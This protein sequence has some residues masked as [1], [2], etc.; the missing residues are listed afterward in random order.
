MYL[1]VSFRHS[2]LYV[3]LLTL[4]YPKQTFIVTKTTWSGHPRC[5]RWKPYK[6]PR[7]C[8]SQDFLSLRP[9]SSPRQK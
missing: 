3:F 1:H 6:A 2:F 9:W 4:N 8:F 7:L 5:S